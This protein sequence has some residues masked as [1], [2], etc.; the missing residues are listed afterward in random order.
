MKK[1]KEVAGTSFAEKEATMATPSRAL[2][3]RNGRGVKR[4]RFRDVEAMEVGRTTMT[5][6]GRG[7]GFHPAGGAR[8]RPRE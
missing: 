7:E 3:V 4:L 8:R 1:T 2:K 6:T 5:R